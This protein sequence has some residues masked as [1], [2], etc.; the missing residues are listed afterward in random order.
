M[1]TPVALLK[2]TCSRVEP[3]CAEYASGCQTRSTAR[4]IRSA[5]IAGATKTPCGRR[6]TTLSYRK[7][8][9]TKNLCGIYTKDGNFKLCEKVWY[10]RYRIGKWLINRWCKPTVYTYGGSNRDFQSLVAWEAFTDTTPR[11]PW[12]KNWLIK[13]ITKLT[14]AQPTYYVLECFDDRS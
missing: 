12:Y 1:G 7:L 14:G 2:C 13:L 3:R 4:R 8:K 6:T 11:H 5:A 9:N 10:M